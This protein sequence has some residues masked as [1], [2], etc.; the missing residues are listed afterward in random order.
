MSRRSRFRPSALLWAVLFLLN[1]AGNGFGLHPCPHH[2]SP[3]GHAAS[4]A[5]ADH[6]DVTDSTTSH[7]A[8]H[9]ESATTAESTASDD[10]SS[11]AHDGP[12]T[13]SGA[14]Q[15][16]S[17]AGL[18]SDRAH[19]PVAAIDA[20]TVGPVLAAFDVLPSRHPPHFLPW[21]L[22]PPAHD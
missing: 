14:C 4:T 10:A 18:P 1:T 19:A 8:H 20:A 12:C 17:V 2:D 5:A 11:D 9:A 13:C 7:H 22:A 3:A 16:G 15:A 21:G 6:G